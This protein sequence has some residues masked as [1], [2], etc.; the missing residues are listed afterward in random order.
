MAKS[1]YAGS[2]FFVINQ[3]CELGWTGSQPLDR[4]YLFALY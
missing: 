4:I 2:P 1:E 3:L